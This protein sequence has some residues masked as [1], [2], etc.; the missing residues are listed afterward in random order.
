MTLSSDHFPYGY[1][2]IPFCNCGQPFNSP[3]DLNEHISAEV[4]RETIDSPVRHGNMTK[5][6]AI[7]RREHDEEQLAVERL[8]DERLRHTPGVRS[9]RQKPHPEADAE[10]RVLRANHGKRGP[11]D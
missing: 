9:L 7:T 6:V 10:D 11:H 8:Q 1:R 3:R 4:A 5:K 2:E